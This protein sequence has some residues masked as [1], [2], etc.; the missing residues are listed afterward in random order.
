MLTVVPF[1]RCRIGGF[2]VQLIRD[3]ALL[4]ELRRRCLC[5]FGRVLTGFVVR[6][7][8]PADVLGQRVCHQLAPPVGGGPAG[9]LSATD[10]STQALYGVQPCSTSSRIAV[11][12]SMMPLAAALVMTACGRCGVFICRSVS[13][14]ASRCVCDSSGTPS[15][16]N[17]ATSCVRSS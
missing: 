14:L 16:L 13:Q 8:H 2:G 1:G 7:M 12:P 15:A 11:C 9:A 4:G 6:T 10:S 5:L 17:A 3:G